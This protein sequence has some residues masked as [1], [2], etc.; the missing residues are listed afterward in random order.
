[1]KNKNYSK[2]VAIFALVLAMA[3]SSLFALPAT[4]CYAQ[5]GY[6]GVGVGGEPVSGLTLLGGKIDAEGV[7]TK[8]VTAKS[9]DKLCQLALDKGTK[10]LSK[11]GGRLSGVV[12]TVLLSR[13][14]RLW[15]PPGVADT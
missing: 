7:L 15:P 10:A 12:M 8:D 3:V 2:M 6:V 9:D 14:K 5:G 4:L 13:R 11:R 1:M